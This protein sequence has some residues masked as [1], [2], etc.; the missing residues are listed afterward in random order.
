MDSA[1]YR[2]NNEATKR[3][4]AF[5]N[6]EDGCSPPAEAERSTK[7]EGSDVQHQAITGYLRH[8]KFQWIDWQETQ[9]E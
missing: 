2:H 3:P 1:K 6:A 4:S 7:Q 9:W 8:L 5:P